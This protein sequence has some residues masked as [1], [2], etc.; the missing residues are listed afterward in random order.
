MCDHGRRCSRF[1]GLVRP[2]AAVALLF[3]TSILCGQ[4]REV[5]IATG[6]WAPYVGRNLQGNGVCARILSAAMEEMGLQPEFV[7]LPWAQALSEAERSDSNTAYWGTFPYAHTD[8]REKLFYYSDP[9]FEVEG[10]IFYNAAR[11]PEFADIESIDELHDLTAVVVEGYAHS[12]ELNSIIA[13]TVEVSNERIAFQKLIEDSTVH[14]L[15]ASRRVGERILNHHFVSQRFDIAILP[16]YSNAS[17]LHVIASRRNPRSWQFINDLNA[18]IARIQKSGVYEELLRN[19][20]SDTSAVVDVVT[21]TAPD[22]QLIIGTDSRDST[23]QI[24]IVSGTRAVVTDWGSAYQETSSH[25]AETADRI[26]RVRVLKGPA[27]GQ[28]IDIDGRFLKLVSE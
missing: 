20:Q 4:R 22:G 24:T 12:A 5:R 1:R 10:V 23:R 27:Q 15:S 11:N 2:L 9:I 19:S 18:A 13:N 25:A 16:Q 6:D 17:K 14:I 3:A 26:C 28:T 7:F 8:D 21:L